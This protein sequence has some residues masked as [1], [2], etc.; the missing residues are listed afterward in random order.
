MRHSYCKQQDMLSRQRNHKC[1]LVRSRC[2]VARDKRNC[3]GVSCARRESREARLVCRSTGVKM[4]QFR[5]YARNK[6]L[7]KELK[8]IHLCV[9]LAET[10]VVPDNF[11]NS[12]TSSITRRALHLG[13]TP[14]FSSADW[15]VLSCT[16]LW[17]HNH[18]CR[19]ETM[20][21]SL[22]LKFRCKQ[23]WT[24]NPVTKLPFELSRP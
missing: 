17:N 21:F 22:L 14:V 18:I 10:S 2:M 1:F 7:P 8:E 16:C 20:C 13:Y 11:N 9:P 3:A 19:K 5:N 6:W 24:W 4:K 12:L 15:K 23:T